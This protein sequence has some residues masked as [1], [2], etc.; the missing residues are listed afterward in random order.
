MSSPKD[1]VLDI[2]PSVQDNNVS[3]LNLIKFTVRNR[4]QD[5]V[6]RF[7]VPLLAILIAVLAAFTGRVLLRDRLVSFSIN[8]IWELEIKR[9]ESVVIAILVSLIVL[10]SLKQVPEDSITVMKGLGVQLS[11]RKSWKFQYRSECFIPVSNTIDLV[12]HEGFHG[13]GQV[14][15]YLCILT[16]SSAVGKTNNDNIIKVAF[17]EF[18][19]RKDILL[20]VW[21][22]SRELLF[23]DAKRYWRRVPGQGL[24]Q[25][26]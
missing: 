6:T 3:D 25:V 18:L 1:Y 14:I 10:V 20:D 26:Y 16:K 9:S 19:P 12:I 17:P 21:K 5:P 13:Y 4:R 2:T 7:K 23:G 22:L 24:K 15:F 8:S 11:S